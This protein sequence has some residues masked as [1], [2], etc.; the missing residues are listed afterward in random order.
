MRGTICSIG[1]GGGDDIFGLGGPIIL[2]WAVRGDCPRHDSG[3]PIF[4]V[5][6]AAT[7]HLD[8][9]YN[10]EGVKCKMRPLSNSE[11]LRVK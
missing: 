1:G 5:V 2:S 8:P 9:I 11:Q 7:R 4:D 10:K 3:T 6:I